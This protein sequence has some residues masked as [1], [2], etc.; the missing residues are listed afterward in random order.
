[1][2]IQALDK[3]F[4]AD[5]KGLTALKKE[6]STQSPEALRET[7]RQFESLFTTMMLKSMRQ[8]TPDDPLFGSDQQSFYQDMFDQQMAVQLSKGKGLGLADMLVQQLMHSAGVADTTDVSPTPTPTTPTTTP[9]PA[10]E[11]V[12][13][14]EKTTSIWPPRTRDDFVRAILP[15]AEAAGRQLG[16]DPNTLVA[17]AALETGWGKSM[18]VNSDG[19][20][21][22]NLFGIKTGVSWKGARVD[23]ATH[24]FQNGR[25]QAVNAGFRAYDSAEQGIADY[26]QFLQGSPR[27]AKALGTGSNVAAFA[28]GLQEGGYATDPDYANKLISVARELKSRLSR[29]LTAS[30]V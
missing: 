24:E 3:S 29:P 1:M 18:P 17:H 7:A 4:Y 30:A 2:T 15:A 16:V 8:A 6:A 5:P 12:P 14:S 20:P 10:S 21:S 23:A 9:T 25:M 22:F 19:Q 27:Y 11:A 28:K 26:A 13:V